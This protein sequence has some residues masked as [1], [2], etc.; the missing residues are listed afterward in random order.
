MKNTS[1]I[2]TIILMI[3]VFMGGC[4]KNSSAPPEKQIKENTSKTL[5]VYTTIFPIEDFTKKIGGK[6]VDVK[7]VYPAGADAHTF[8][9]TLKA[10]MDIADADL[11]IYNGAGLEMFIDKA[12]KTLANEKVEMVEASKGIELLRGH[13][14]NHGDHEHEHG[15]DHTDGHAHEN[16]DEEHGHEATEDEHDGHNHGHEDG[17]NHEAGH[18]EHGHED[19]TEDK[20]DHGHE[21]GTEEYDHHDHGHHHHDQDPHVWLD[22]I[23]AIKMAEN[24]K[25][26]L[27]EALPSAKDEFDKNF[28]NLKEELEQLDVDLRDTIDSAEHKELLVSH[29]S[30]GY[31]QHR[32]GIHQISIAGLSPE[33][34]PSQKHLQSIIETTKEHGIHYIIYDQIPST[35]VVKVVQKE[36]G[37]KPVTLHNLEYL[38]EDDIKNKEDYFSIMNKNIETL[39]TVLGK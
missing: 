19:H 39:K 14:H 38:T 12:E 9:P 24:I 8:E 23:H 13:D 11:F 29:A 27:S 36:T 31:W 18:E 5:K 17:H 1:I 7:S 28:Q 4:N 37:T 22:P 16:G 6:Y 2:F 26:A 10:M 25:D 34:E 20:H 15:E 21:E 32:Y 30:Y 33:N 35:K 3:A